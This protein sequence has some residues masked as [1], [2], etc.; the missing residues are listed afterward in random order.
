MSFRSG[1]D[2]IRSVRGFLVEGEGHSGVDRD[3]RAVRILAR[4]L[5]WISAMPFSMTGALA[6]WWWY[7][8]TLMSW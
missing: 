1:S 6:G 3:V 7:T 2:V 8:R 4:S 5:V